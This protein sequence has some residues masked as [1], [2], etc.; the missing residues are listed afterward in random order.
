M[1]DYTFTIPELRVPKEFSIWIDKDSSD[2]QKQIQQFLGNT[3]YNQNQSDF[4]VE[5]A[6]HDYIKLIREWA[7]DTFNIPIANAFHVRT[8]PNKNGI[9][10]CEGPTLSSRRMAFNFLVK[11]E[12]GNTGSQWGI[13]PEWATTRSPLDESAERYG[14]I[15]EENQSKVEV[16]GEHTNNTMYECFA[17]NTTILHRSINE[18]SSTERVLLSLTIPEKFSMA[19]VQKMYNE[20]NLIK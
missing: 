7:N 14:Q 10:H 20:G 9:W 17:Y 1:S 6:H 18:N 11:G 2:Q 16:M 3:I 19:L 4:A 13:Y 12:P 8:A 5:L 15:K